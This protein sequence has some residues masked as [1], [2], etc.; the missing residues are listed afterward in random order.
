MLNF[1]FILINIDL[2][3]IKFLL[4]IFEILYSNY[5]ILVYR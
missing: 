3:S 4:K 1:E 5:K 2:I